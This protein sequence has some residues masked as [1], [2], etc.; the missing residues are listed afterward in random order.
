[1][2]FT[3]KQL[4][5]LSPWEENFRTAVLAQWARNPGRSGLRVIYDIFTSVTG[6]TRRFN[7]NCNHCILHLLQ[8]CGRIY[9]RDKEELEKMQKS[10]KEVDVSQVAAEPVKKV[11]VKTTR[12]R[13][14]KKYKD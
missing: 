9:F 4:K 3:E 14:T 10:A 7:D 1:M 8:D 11:E 13:T 2:T 12:K 5:D 6:D